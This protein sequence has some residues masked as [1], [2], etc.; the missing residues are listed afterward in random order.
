[1]TMLLAALLSF[2]LPVL[3][4]DAPAAPPSEGAIRVKDTPKERKRV[5]Q[6]FRAL[7]TSGDGVIDE[8]E[9]A[10]YAKKVHAAAVKAAAKDKSVK[11]QSEDEILVSLKKEL[12]SA[13]AKHDGKITE[14]AYD[15]YEE[16]LEK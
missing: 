2:A 3:A 10:A 15:Q 9:L 5:H 12:E 4:A 6:H 1:M 11:V 16:P 14:A 8:K 13:D 7:D